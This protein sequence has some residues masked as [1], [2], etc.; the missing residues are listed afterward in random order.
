MPK[1]EA[2]RPP[3]A[4]K[5]G[6]VIRELADEV[7][8]YDLEK[9]RA[10]CLNKTAAAVWKRCDGETTV[11]EIAKAL[12]KDL[13]EPVDVELVWSALDRLQKSRLLTDRVARPIE[14]SG[15]TR[16]EAL[17]RVGLAAAI[18]SIIAPTAANAQTIAGTVTPAACRARMAKGAGC[19]NTPCTTGGN[20][21][22]IAASGNCKC[23]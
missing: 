10:F 5:D 19:G 7:L 17:R 15:I 21:K 22:Q 1:R 3:R 8:V 9:H 23:Q 6:L 18:T 12:T 13:N 2:L 4:R 20:C 16:R 11:Q 14:R